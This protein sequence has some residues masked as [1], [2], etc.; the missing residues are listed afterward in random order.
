[1]S[2]KVDGGSNVTILILRF[3]PRKI[4]PKNPDTLMNAVDFNGTKTSEIIVS[5]T[6]CVGAVSRE[7]EL[8]TPIMA[9]LRDPIDAPSAVGGESTALIADTTPTAR[10]CIGYAP[11][12]LSPLPGRAGGQVG[13]TT[14]RGKWEPGSPCTLCA[15]NSHNTL[16][17]SG[18]STTPSPTQSGRD[19]RAEAGRPKHHAHLHRGPLFRTVADA[20]VGGAIQDR[21]NQ[22]GSRNMELYGDGAQADVTTVESPAPREVQLQR[23]LKPAKDPAKAAKI[24]MPHSN[25]IR[26]INTSTK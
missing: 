2:Y 14:N 9:S 26:H 25:P 16:A 13:N 21:T 1:M 17:S 19:A 8:S 20:I 5:A 18:L 12:A 7:V 3:S 24:W 23:P 4:V 22:N 10:A 15:M 6:D 11:L